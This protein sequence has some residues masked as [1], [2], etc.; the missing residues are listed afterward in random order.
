MSHHSDDEDKYGGDDPESTVKK[1]ERKRQREKQ[2]RSDLASAFDELSSL[3]AKAEN[4]GQPDEGKRGGR[5]RRSSV[6]DSSDVHSVEASGMT[7]LDIIGRTIETMRRLIQENSDLKNAVTA[8][9]S[10][11]PPGDENKVRVDGEPSHTL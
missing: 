5:K 1:S 11:G 6:G 2:R 8:Y 4:E 7:R 10:R 9:R 3:L